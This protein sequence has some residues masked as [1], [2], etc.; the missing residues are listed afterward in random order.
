MKTTHPASKSLQRSGSAVLILLVLLSLMAIL[1]TS[2][3]T[4]LRQMRKELDLME[5]Q[6]IKKFVPPPSPLPVQTNSIPATNKVE[7][8]GQ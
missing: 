2:N 3:H 8:S 1:T 4:T 7:P 5:L 6:Q